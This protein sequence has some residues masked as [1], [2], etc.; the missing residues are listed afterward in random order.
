M[1]GSANGRSITASTNRLPRKSSRVST[2]ATSSPNTALTTVT[3]SEIVSVTLKDSSAALEV[4]VAQKSC[5]PPLAD[6]H[7]IAASGSSTMTLSQIDAA[8]TRRLVVPCLRARKPDGPPG[9][10]G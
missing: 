3:P 7:T 1:V 6:C 9:S 4:T 5:Q 8:P 2:Q 10:L